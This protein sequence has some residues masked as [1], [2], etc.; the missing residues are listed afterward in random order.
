MIHTVLPNTAPSVGEKTKYLTNDIFIGDLKYLLCNYYYLYL[1]IHLVR[2][3]FV[4][5]TVQVRDIY[6]SNWCYAHMWGCGIPHVGCGNITC[7]S[8]TA[9]K[10]GGW[11]HHMWAWHNVDTPIDGCCIEKTTTPRVDIRIWKIEKNISENVCVCKMVWKKKIHLENEETFI[12]ENLE[13]HGDDN[14]YSTANLD[15]KGALY[16]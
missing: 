11:Q 6:P 14:K 8:V 10:V 16:M 2:R 5:Y 13:K 7:R 9:S 3:A 1:D 15:L 12:R 4:V